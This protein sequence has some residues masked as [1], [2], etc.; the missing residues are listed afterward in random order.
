MNKKALILVIELIGLRNFGSFQCFTQSKWDVGFWFVRHAQ[1]WRHNNLFKR[2][3]KPDVAWILALLH[4]KCEYYSGKSF[5]NFTYWC[6]LFLFYVI[7]CK[8]S[9][10]PKWQSNNT[11]KRIECSWKSQSTNNLLYR[12]QQFRRPLRHDKKTLLHWIGCSFASNRS[13]NNYAE[14]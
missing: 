11:W 9:W 6:Y 2:F 8:Q 13:Q 14:R 10:D 3:N 5:D 7:F 1:K 4:R 12:F